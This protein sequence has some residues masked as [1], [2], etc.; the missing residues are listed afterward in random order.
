MPTHFE[1]ATGP[2]LVQGAIA[3]VDDSTGRARDIQRVQERV[4]G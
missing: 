2:V 3:D 4:A 1:V